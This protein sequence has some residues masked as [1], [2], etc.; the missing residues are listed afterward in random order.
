M[1]THDRF[2]HIE[3][4]DH[5]LKRRDGHAGDTEYN[6]EPRSIIEVDSEGGQEL[7]SPVRH[8]D[9]GDDTE[10][11]DTGEHNDSSKDIDFKRPRLVRG[12][13]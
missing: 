1:M 13:S 4:Y 12:K 8:S 5:I 11:R 6:V 9:D 7:A 3:E 10:R 2:K